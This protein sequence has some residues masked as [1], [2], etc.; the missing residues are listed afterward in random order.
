[1][2]NSLLTPSSAAKAWLWPRS[3]LLTVSSTKGPRTLSATTIGLTCFTWNL[4]PRLIAFWI[5]NPRRRDEQP[6]DES[7]QSPQDERILRSCLQVRETFPY[8]TPRK[9]LIFD[10]AKVRVGT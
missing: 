6:P 4:I 10:H 1:M 5:R 7:T 3:I 2:A 8:D 9:C